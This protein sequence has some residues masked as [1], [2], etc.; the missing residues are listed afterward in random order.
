MQNQHNS[1]T[2]GSLQLFLASMNGLD[3][4]ELSKAKELYLRNAISEYISEKKEYLFEKES[5]DIFSLVFSSMH[6]RRVKYAEI[7]LGESKNRLENTLLV[8]K[9]DLT[10]CYTE[11]NQTIK[12]LD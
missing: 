6:K 9:D 1:L 4:A 3:K 2:P 11:L 7:N 8:W 12:N 5:S 10:H